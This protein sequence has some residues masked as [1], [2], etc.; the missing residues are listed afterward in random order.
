MPNH[1]ICIFSV[2]YT[3]PH[4]DKIFLLSKKGANL[5]R[6]FPVFYMFDNKNKMLET[7]FR[8]TCCSILTEKMNRNLIMQ[9]LWLHVSTKIFDFFRELNFEVVA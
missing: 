2:A 1:A 8:S 9:D 6:T 7:K 5:Y 4:S 3:Y